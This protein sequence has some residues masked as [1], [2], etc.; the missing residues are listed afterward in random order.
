MSACTLLVTVSALNALYALPY[1]LRP[2]KPVHLCLIA[3]GCDGRQHTQ[4]APAFLQSDALAHRGF[5]ARSRRIPV[6]ALF[7]HATRSK[8]RLVLCGKL[9]PFELDDMCLLV[10]SH[11]GVPCPYPEASCAIW[12]CCML[13]SV[14]MTSCCDKHCAMAIAY[15]LTVHVFRDL[16][17]SA[18]HC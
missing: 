3:W 15:C 14:G 13:S 4:K 9:R 2:D 16:A 1:V 7:A 18:Q 17:S 5:L 6:E 11:H 8:K 12:T 10:L